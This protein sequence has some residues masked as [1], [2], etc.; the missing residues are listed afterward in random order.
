MSSSLKT[1][2]RHKLCD[3]ISMSEVATAYFISTNLCRFLNSLVS[4]RLV[5]FEI[6]KE[7]VDKRK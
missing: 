6:E 5:R 7:V 3:H 4:L 2:I 1:K